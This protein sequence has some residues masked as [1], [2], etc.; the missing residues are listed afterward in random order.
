[1]MISRHI[2]AISGGIVY[3]DHIAVQA[4]NMFLIMRRW[5]AL[6]LCHYKVLLVAHKSPYRFTGGFF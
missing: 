5:I 3:R 4:N 2:M 1:M 6:N